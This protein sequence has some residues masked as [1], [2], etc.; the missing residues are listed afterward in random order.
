[1]NQLLLCC[2]FLT[3]FLAT[4]ATTSQNCDAANVLDVIPEED[5]IVL[6]IEDTGVQAFFG[7]DFCNPLYTCSHMCSCGKNV[8]LGLKKMKTWKKYKNRFHKDCRKNSMRTYLE[9]SIRRISMKYNFFK[10]EAVKNVLAD[11]MKKRIASIKGA[12]RDPSVRAKIDDA[13][14]SVGHWFHK[15]FLWVHGRGFSKKVEKKDGKRLLSAFKAKVARGDFSFCSCMMFINYHNHFTRIHKK[16]AL[17][18]L[19]HKKCQ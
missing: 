18:G 13:F 2:L 6:D 10:R 8:Y 3:L 14:S 11:Y 9:Q 4:K 7:N 5:E 12:C 1:M 19:C 15:N 16:I 17:M